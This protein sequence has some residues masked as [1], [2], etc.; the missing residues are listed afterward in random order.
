LIGALALV[1][2]R[3]TEGWFEAASADSAMAARFDSSSRACGLIAVA[4]SAFLL[5][6]RFTTRRRLFD[7]MRALAD[8]ATV[9]VLLPGRFATNRPLT[10]GVCALTGAVGSAAVDAFGNVGGGSLYQ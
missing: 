5:L 9:T 6:A 3:M 8:F 2:S 7:G 4:T 10:C 1:V